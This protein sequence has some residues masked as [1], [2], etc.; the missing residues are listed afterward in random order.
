M[1][2]SQL[3]VTET[4]SWGPNDP[5]IWR[6]YFL[7]KELVKYLDADD[8]T[9]DKA[10]FVA[11]RI[12]DELET[13]LAHYQTIMSDDFDKLNLSKQRA[14]YEGLY[15]DLWTL[16]KDKMQK[17]LSEIGIDIGFIFAKNDADFQKKANIFMEN[18][19][20]NK[21]Y[22]AFAKKQRNKWQNAFAQSRNANEH[23]GD[24]RGGVSDFNNRQ[25]ATR[26]FAQVCWTYETIISSLVSYKLK[27]EWNVIEIN[28]G[29]TVF[30]R[31]DRYKIEHCV[32][33][34]QRERLKDNNS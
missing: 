25:D 31:V 1:I 21:E 4:S 10:D 29:V 28:E 12:K 23:D 32:Q 33:T 5:D 26:L 19:S 9:K 27:R 22:I 6:P 17:Y 7:A 18:N 13:A 3:I 15:S 14:A 8:V 30:D 20:Q 11:D 24:L 16:Y 2:R 34:S